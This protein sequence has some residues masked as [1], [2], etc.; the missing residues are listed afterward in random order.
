MK[1]VLFIYQDDSLPSSRI[2]VLNILPEI[3][4]FDILPTAVRYPKTLFEKLKILKK[5]REFDTIYLQKKLPT[6]Y[7][8]ILYRKN[9]RKLVF[10]FD[11][12]IYYKDDSH[13]S[14]ESKTRYLKFKYLLQNVDYVVAGN[15][16]LADYAGKFHKNVVVIPSA[17][18]TRNIPVKDYSNITDKTVIGWVG[19]K[20][21]LRHLEMLLPVLQRL[22]KDYK[23]Q[24]NIVSND[25]ISAPGVDICSI[26]WSLETQ[27]KEIALFDIGIMP[28]PNNKWTEGKCGYKA[29]QY[30]AAAVPPVCSDVGINREIVENGKEGFVVTS[31]ED[32]YK[33][34]CD[35]ITNKGL[36][37]EMGCNARVKA[38][39]QFSIHVVAK[40]LADFLHCLI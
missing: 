13:K 17:V 22:S 20:G 28:L 2:R 8:T 12:A 4:N 29:L 19:G 30:M 38:E 39:K 18:E 26:P 36:R 15:R 40:K 33:S 27:E 35:L 24:L 21:N 1:K 16:I 23:I 5:A 7:E 25:T 37:K 31:Q 3:Q 9:A 6:P 34:L 10:D 11:D 14:F 32:F